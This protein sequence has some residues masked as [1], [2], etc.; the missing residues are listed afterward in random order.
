VKSNIDLNE[1]LQITES[2]YFPEIWE[3]L[4]QKK[5]FNN[6]SWYI[7]FKRATDPPL[8]WDALEINQPT[9]VFVLGDESNYLPL[10]APAGVKAIFVSYL[11]IPSPDERIFHLPVGPNPGVPLKQIREFSRR[12]NNV[13]FSGNLHTGRKALYRVF[14]GLGFLPFFIHHR[15]RNWLG[16]EFHDF[17][18]PSY[19]RFTDKFLTGLPFDEYASVLYD[20]RIVLC[21]QGNPGTETMRHYEALRA[22]C[23]V[24]SKS[25]HPVNYLSSAP[26]VYLDHWKDLRGVVAELLNNKE[27]LSSISKQ[28]LRWWQESGSPHAV[29][30]QI[31]EKIKIIAH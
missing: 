13:F 28:S 10:G 8:Q 6:Y 21:P 20:S 24:V 25:F 7:H 27:R 16:T 22:G 3:N 23:V 4:Q 12:T 14:T 9:I 29:A 30:E 18:G 17:F 31:H 26:I 19:I 2:G 11:N 1:I 5:E 15:L